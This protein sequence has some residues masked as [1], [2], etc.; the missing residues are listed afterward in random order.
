MKNI[1]CSVI[2]SMALVLV[3]VFAYATSSL[4]FQGGGYWLDMEIGH[5]DRPVVASID[6][7]APGDS[8]GVV[9]RD[10]YKVA[11]FDTGRKYLSIEYSGSDPRVQPFTLIVHGEKAILRIGRT[12]IESRF[13]WFMW[14]DIERRTIHSHQ[15]E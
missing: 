4:S 5:A 9:L 12:R 10:N 1:A 8:Q 3:P 14:R 2:L 15:P 7:H 11:S 13:D 6:F